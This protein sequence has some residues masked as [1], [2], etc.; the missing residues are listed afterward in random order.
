MYFF[1]RK[2]EKHLETRLRS[3]C[4]LNL[5]PEEN[6]QLYKKLAKK[7]SEIK[8][9]ELVTL[10]SISS[11]GSLVFTI[12]LMATKIFFGVN[13]IGKVKDPGTLSYHWTSNS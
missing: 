11:P 2:S 13:A 6:L 4:A 5:R 10:F 1:I 8:V 3:F 12:V 9:S 7:V